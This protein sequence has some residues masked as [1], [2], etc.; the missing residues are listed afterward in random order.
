MEKVSLIFFHIVASLG[1]INGANIL[2]VF[3]NN[4]MSHWIVY[5]GVLKALAARGHN[6]TVITSFPQK[7]PV[8][9]YTDIDVSDKESNEVNSMSIDLV[10]NVISD[11]HLNQKYIAQFQ[12]ELCKKVVKNAQVQDLLQ[13]NIKF[14]VVFLVFKL[15]S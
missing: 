9:N 12:L 11:V 2:G 4:G 14:D 1:I 8:S 7:I 3:P 5:E 6:I 13:S 10:Q 15:L